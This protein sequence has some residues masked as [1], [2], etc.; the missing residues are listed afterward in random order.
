ML[1]TEENLVQNVKVGEHIANSDHNIIRGEINIAK[2]LE[3]NDEKIYNYK[4]GDFNQIRE[5]L[6]T[7]RHLICTIYSQIN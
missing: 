3:K 5:K 4:R 1:S 2:K 6:E 7:R